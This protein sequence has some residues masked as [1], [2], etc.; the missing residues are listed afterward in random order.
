MYLSKSNINHRVSKVG[1]IWR[2]SSRLKHSWKLG[3]CIVSYT[4]IMQNKYLRFQRKGEKIE[5]RDS[6]E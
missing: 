6:G 5:L 4:K 2:F 1:W 3:Q